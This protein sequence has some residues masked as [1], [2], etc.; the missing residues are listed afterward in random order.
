[1]VRKDYLDIEAR[2]MSKFARMTV[3]EIMGVYSGLLDSW[4]FRNNVESE[5]TTWRTYGKKS[6][7]FGR[8]FNMIQM[9]RDVGFYDPREHCEEYS[10]A[11]LY[12]EHLG[13]FYSLVYAIESEFKKIGD[14]R[15][16][17]HPMFS[18]KEDDGMGRSILFD[19]YNIDK[20]FRIAF[21]HEAAFTSESAVRHA[22]TR[23]HSAPDPT[24]CD[25]DSMPTDN[26]DFRERSAN[27]GRIA[28]RD[29]SESITENFEGPILDE[30]E[31]V[32][33]NRDMLDKRLRGKL[34]TKFKKVVS[35]AIAKYE[36]TDWRV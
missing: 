12:G 30:Q 27:G 24:W 32:N 15:I 13:H 14:K 20:G 7:G 36:K 1:M 21:P 17:M 23:A 16:L 34:S 28:A 19:R 26:R 11:C 35:G 29:Y 6:F 22:E 8:S 33:E 5:D 31:Y 2:D 9:M 10:S 25:K 4:F 3:F 18:Q